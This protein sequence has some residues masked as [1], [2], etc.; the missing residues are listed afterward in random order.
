MDFFVVSGAGSRPGQVRKPENQA[1]QPPEDN[2]INSPQGSPHFGGFCESFHGS[3][4]T[5]GKRGVGSVGAMYGNQKFPPSE[6][7]S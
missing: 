4:T 5:N 6:K 1:L 2:K 3:K 7:G